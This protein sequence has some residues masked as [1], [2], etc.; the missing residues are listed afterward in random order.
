MDAR[1]IMTKE[2]AC[3]TP[4]QSVRDAAILMVEQ[5]CGQIPVV[6]Q[7]N[8]LVGVLTDR[9]IACRCVAEGLSADTKVSE[10]MTKSPICVSPDDS[11]DDCCK[12]MEDNQIRRLPVVDD[13][14]KCCGMLSQ[15][16]IATNAELKD[17]GDLVREVSQPSKESV[18]AGCC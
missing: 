18:K 2:P 7:D 3:C 15:A 1:Q 10:V 13:S 9:D 14:G 17:T 11:L 6:D 4:E 8:V 12:K 5:N 16:D